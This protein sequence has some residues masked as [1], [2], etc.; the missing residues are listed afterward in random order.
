MWAYTKKQKYLSTSNPT[1]PSK[2]LAQWNAPHTVKRQVPPI[3]VWVMPLNGP[4]ETFNHCLDKDPRPILAPAINLHFPGAI[5][6]VGSL[7]ISRVS[8]GYRKCPICHGVYWRWETSD[9]KTIFLPVLEMNK[10]L[11]NAFISLEKD[12][13]GRHP[14]ANQEFN[15]CSF[16]YVPEYNHIC[17]SNTEVLMKSRHMK[18]P[19]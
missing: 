5:T 1:H 11:S 14:T 13:G 4:T 3:Q 6:E 8:K 2:R 9:W 12:D 15:Q 19:L 18:M 7:R 16:T 10:S 17:K